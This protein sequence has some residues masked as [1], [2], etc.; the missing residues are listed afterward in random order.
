MQKALIILSGWRSNGEL[1]TDDLDLLN[2]YLE[3]GWKVVSSCYMG[4]S[5]ESDMMSL[6]VID[7]SDIK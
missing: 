7:D 1:N 2:D 4:S 6:V 3:D 5:S